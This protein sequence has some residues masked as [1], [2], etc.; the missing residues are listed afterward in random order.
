MSIDSSQAMDI[1]RV[2]TEALPYI[3]RFQ[4]KTLVIK[5]GGNA[6]VDVVPYAGHQITSAMANALIE[7]LRATRSDVHA[8]SAPPAT[9]AP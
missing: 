2:L 4:G 8:S 5:Y 9:A 6:T 3:R 7:R 1:A